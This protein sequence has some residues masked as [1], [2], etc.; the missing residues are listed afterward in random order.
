MEY[1]TQDGEPTTLYKL[2]RSEPDWAASRIREGE[3]AQQEIETLRLE[4]DSLQR[5]LNSEILNHEQCLKTAEIAFVSRDEWK[6][7]Y[8][9]AWEWMGTR[10]GYPEAKKYSEEFICRIPEAANWF[11]EE[12]DADQKGLWGLEE[13]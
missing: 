5:K 7:R 4:N 2:V 6:R 1:K 10:Y 11:E 13:Q 3:K 8:T 12:D 9:L